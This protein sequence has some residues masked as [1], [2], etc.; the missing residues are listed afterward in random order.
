M[1]RGLGARS[2]RVHRR[3][4]QAGPGRT[5]PPPRASPSGLAWLAM[6][7][8]RTFAPHVPCIAKLLHQAGKLVVGK[9]TGQP[10][11][12]TKS[13]IAPAQAKALVQPTGSPRRETAAW[14]RQNIRT[15]QQSTAGYTYRGGAA[16]LDR[17]GERSAQSSAHDPPAMCGKENPSHR[18]TA[19]D[20]ARH[21]V[22]PSSD[23]NIP[24]RGSVR[25]ACAAFR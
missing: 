13:S 4:R 10:V 2:S 15:R 16:S 9:S 20:T 23:S 1:R 21:K 6:P 5:S 8:S 14:R 7:C 3:Q 17:R 25:L 19:T 11:P 24:S 12:P 18:R 22:T